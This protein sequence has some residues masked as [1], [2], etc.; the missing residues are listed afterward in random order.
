M[1]APQSAER[2]GLLDES[3]RPAR[4][5]ESEDS[6]AGDVLAFAPESQVHEPE[7]DQS[8]TVLGLHNV[9]CPRKQ[10]AC[11]SFLTMPFCR[12]H[13]CCRSSSSRC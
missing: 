10:S 8:G 5:S 2:E 13:S 12:W 9:S 11:P 3:E 7:H 1:P 4:T 6:D